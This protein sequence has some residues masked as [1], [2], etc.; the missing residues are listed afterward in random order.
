LNNGLN[1]TTAKVEQRPNI[2]NGNKKDLQR[3]L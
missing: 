3:P 1:D 2:Y